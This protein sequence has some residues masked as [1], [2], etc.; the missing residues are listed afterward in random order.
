M[1]AD[2]IPIDTSMRARS[3]IPAS[4]SCVK[5]CV[6]HGPWPAAFANHVRVLIN[7]ANE[8]LSGPQRASF[9]RGGPLP[10]PPS[11]FSWFRD[12]SAETGWD[13][14]YPQ[15][16]VDGVVH[17]QGGEELKAALI[18]AAPSIGVRTNGDLLRCQIGDAVLTAHADG[19]TQRA[20]SAMPFDAIVHTVAP[21]YPKGAERN[22]PDALAKWRS[23]LLRCY[24]SS[25]AAAIGFAQDAARRDNQSVARLAIATPVLGSGA[26]GAPLECA[27]RVLAQA[28]VQHFRATEP[29]SDGVPVSLRVVTHPN[30]SGRTEVSIVEAALEEAASGK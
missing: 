28:A 15:Q 22:D 9:P 25:F 8:S 21:F 14:L 2:P 7:P 4:V 16:S 27:S 10:P 17:L 18:A 5:G 24:E 6:V 11:A 12:E 23:S 13:L 30:A 3:L 20:D 26:R 19:R 29:A 1:S